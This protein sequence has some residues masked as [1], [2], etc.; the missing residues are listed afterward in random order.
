MSLVSVEQYRRI[1]HDTS[2]AEDDVTEQ[3][4]AAEEL[5]AEY[6]RRPGRF[7]HGTYTDRL[8]LYRAENAYDGAWVVYPVATPVTAATGLTVLNPRT[9]AGVSPDGGPFLEGL[10]GSGT[11]PYATVTYSGGWTAETLPEAV[12]REIAKAA[13]L[14][15]DSITSTIPAGATSLR[16]G[17][18]AV[19]FGPGGAGA[20][21][22][23][24][25]AKSSLRRYMRRR[26][27]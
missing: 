22:L 18:A 19:G 12:R 3:L 17:D 26:A 25:I 13:R 1:T 5:V 9:I 10:V 8:R 6:L 2:S 7:V 14:G 20:V 24:S 23:T 27:A 21:E 16:L 11:Q 15:L 4:D